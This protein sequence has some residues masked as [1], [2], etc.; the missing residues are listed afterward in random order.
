MASH[1]AY[2]K[3]YVDRLKLGVFLPPRGGHDP[4]HSNECM[5]LRRGPED[6]VLG[7][8]PAA[9]TL[10]TRVLLS[11][12]RSRRFP[13]ATTYPKLAES[14][15]LRRTLAL[16][17]GCSVVLSEQASRVR[18]ARKPVSP[19]GNYSFPLFCLPADYPGASTVESVAGVATPGAAP[20]R[21]LSKFPARP[22]LC[23]TCLFGYA[24]TGL[25]LTQKIYKK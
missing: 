6:F 17:R 1:S 11:S 13:R 10:T 24:L 20:S 15:L 18:A 5:L 16:C 23:R 3:S 21:A 2:H 7:H 12:L 14:A 19:L 8:R 4:K 22:P 25:V 9:T